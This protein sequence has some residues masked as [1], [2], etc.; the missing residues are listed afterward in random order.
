MTE[1]DTIYKQILIAKKTH[2]RPWSI[3]FLEAPNNEQIG[4]LQKAYRFTWWHKTVPQLFVASD[5]PE[6][7]QQGSR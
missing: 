1:V 3:V 6:D 2:P 7:D 4:A 5:T